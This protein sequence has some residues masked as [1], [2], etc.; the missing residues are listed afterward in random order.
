MRYIVV[1]LCL[2]SL[3]LVS[4]QAQGRAGVI[5][6]FAVQQGE[7]NVDNPPQGRSAG[8]LLLIGTTLRDRRNRAIGFGAM[9]CIAFGKVLPG[10]ISQCAASFVLPLG[11]I[12]ATGTR[13][14]RDFYV[15]AV[16]GGTG[17]YSRASGTLVA[18]TV[19]LTPRRERLLFSLES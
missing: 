4:D 18:S 14:R 17:I 3:L 15:L 2:G 12:T 11:K 7:T 1:A 13:S 9:T 10:A 8:D 16:T 6:I 5:R 19:A